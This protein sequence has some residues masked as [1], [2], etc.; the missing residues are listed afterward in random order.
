MNFKVLKWDQNCLQV[1]APRFHMKMTPVSSGAFS[2]QSYN[3][4]TVSADDSDTFARN[5][6]WE[7]ISITWDTSDYLWYTTEWVLFY[8]VLHYIIP[9]P[10]WDIFL[11]Q[12]F[13]IIHC[14]LSWNLET[15]FLV[16]CTF[17][18]NPVWI[19]NPMKDFWRTDSIL[20]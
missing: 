12:N 6:L 19:Y 20:F 17:L 4:Q 18:L 16:S 13:K 1:S 15:H 9:S 2:W 3:E 10:Y 8:Y 5:G 7:Q 14:C 11:F